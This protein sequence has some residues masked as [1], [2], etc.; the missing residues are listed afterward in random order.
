MK[1]GGDISVSLV[2]QT[3]QKDLSSYCRSLVPVSCAQPE[4]LYGV[5]GQEVAFPTAVR[6]SGGL[7]YSGTGIGD[8]TGG[9]FTALPSEDFNAT[10]QWNRNT[11]F[12]SITG[13][14]MEDSGVYRVK[15]D[16]KQD[17]VYEL[18]V[19]IPVSKP[20]VSYNKH[21]CTLLCSVTRGTQVTLSW[22]R[23]GEKES[24]VSYPVRSAPYLDMTEAVD[25]SGTYT[26][27][28]VNSI[29]R[30]TDSVTVG[31]ECAG[32]NAGQNTTII[33]AVIVGVICTAVGVFIGWRC[34]RQ[35]NHRG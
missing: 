12:F 29:S 7:S 35:Q 14:K 19:Y 10:V 4:E 1:V 28:A 6:N 15:N 2:N 26:C 11:G 8:V 31:V 27:E 20:S 5:V 23:E 3:P 13:L 34:R 22:Y 24:F 21:S 25:Q 30:E 17:T 18:T 33:V 32:A 16:A 9:Q